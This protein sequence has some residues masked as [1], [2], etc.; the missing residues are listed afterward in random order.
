MIVFGFLSDIEPLVHFHILNQHYR[1]EIEILNIDY[2]ITTCSN[3][4]QSE[5]ETKLTNH[6]GKAKITTQVTRHIQQS[7]RQHELTIRNKHKPYKAL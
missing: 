3:E 4:S 2:Q 1:V 5:R 6:H 7:G